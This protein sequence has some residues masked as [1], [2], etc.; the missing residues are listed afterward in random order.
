MTQR[1]AKPV[2][3]KGSNSGWM[4]THC[5]SYRYPVEV[6][7][8]GEIKSTRWKTFEVNRETLE[9]SLK[10]VLPV[11]IVCGLTR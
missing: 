11:E 8:F 5:I 6:E 4:L 2:P 3:I 10:G 7:G 9:T 1:Q